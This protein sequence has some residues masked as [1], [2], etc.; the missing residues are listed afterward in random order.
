MVDT[1]VFV[2]REAELAYL[3]AALQHIL[4]GRGQ[5]RLISGKAGAGKSSLVGEFVRLAQQSYPDI[6][7]AAG[8]C[9]PQT[10]I[11]DPYLPFREI[12]LKMM[13]AAEPAQPASSPAQPLSKRMKQVAVFSMEA[14]LEVGPDL[15][16]MVL[17]GG[18][19]LAQVGRLAVEKT[20]WL[21]QF[22]ERFNRQEIQGDLKIASG[23]TQDQVFEQY[24][25]VL[26]KIAASVP[27]ILVVDD[28]HWADA[29]SLELLFHLCRRLE[30][31]RILLVGTFRP[32]ELGVGSGGERHPLD[33]L[34]NELKRY[35]G[36]ILL[37]LDA[38]TTERGRQ[39]VEALI[40]AEPND[41]DEIFR[42]SLFSHTRGHPLFT[43]EILR[44]LRESSGVVQSPGGKWI[45]SPQLDWRRLPAR[46][47]GVIAERISR[48][49]VT[50]QEELTVASIEGE[51]FTAEVVAAL[52]ERDERQLVRRLSGELQRIHQLVESD[53]LV[54]V[55]SQRLATYRFSHSLIW[56][57]LYDRVDAIEK[58]YL[59]EE[60]AKTLESLYGAFTQAY[61]IQLAYH[62]EQ[63]QVSDKAATYLL[64]A[65]QQSAERFAHETA[66]EYL[67]RAEGFLSG[68]RIAD[69]IELFETRV[70]I[71]AVLGDRTRQK[72]ALQEF[73][74][75]AGLT[76]DS[77]QIASARFY[78]GQYA[79]DTGDL[80]GAVEIGSHLLREI[81]D[82][83]PGTPAVEQLRVNASTLMGQGLRLRGS[84]PEARQLLAQAVDWAQQAEYLHGQ[85]L[86]L[87][88]LSMTY[89][90]EGD[91]ASAEPYLEDA[92]S[93]TQQ[94]DDPHREWSV[95][96]NLGVIAREQ[97]RSQEAITF[98]SRALEIARKIGDRMGESTALTNLGEIHFQIGDYTLARRYLTDAEKL[99]AEIGDRSGA[100]IS[101]AN[102]GE[103]ARALG[104]LPLAGKFAR[105]A[106]TLFQKTGFRMGQGIILGNLALMAQ[107]SGRA[108]LQRKFAEQSLAVA[109]EV[110]DRYGE[111]TSLNL[112]AQA[113]FATGETE[114]AG[115]LF[116]R[117][118][119]VWSKQ[120]DAVGLFQA[121]LGLA[122]C[123]LHRG[124]ASA[125]QLVMDLASQLAAQPDS[126][127]KLPLEV[128]LE[129][130]TTLAQLEKNQSLGDGALP[131]Q[132]LARLA[133]Q[134]LETRAG[135]ITDPADRQA[136]L[137]NVALHRRVLALAG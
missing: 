66:L 115:L 91:Y 105:Q 22:R 123:A 13:A 12:M 93:I 137:Q 95:L 89:W 47:E 36:E 19:F 100:G 50:V 63:A 113:M 85:V 72:D 60:T 108:D 8:L 110:S 55:G 77:L 11:K 96:S 84:I 87:N 109:L 24:S 49:P 78:E 39:F 92:L 126:L 130:Y 17:P 45:A 71:Y 106:F 53:R 111:G 103:C 119:D 67:V 121:Q 56:K 31:S 61:A 73:I 99:A 104:D 38:A 40:D 101:L 81:N 54:H 88:Q 97:G 43:V 64:I 129:L 79:L 37:D 34:I 41:L 44:D 5:L 68:S 65:G 51:L 7:Q 26:K 128:Y 124:D 32:E 3:D 80:D 25:N 58:A 122:G 1:P 46:V 134:V 98:Y 4:Q 136:F 15:A 75:L 28:L 10:G 120:E 74:K 132:D 57:Y 133:R 94:L 6:V 52:L 114:E 33:K 112:L 125:A 27:L 131:A 135:R 76:R 14:V 127:E 30:N 107:T 16:G 82:L 70:K 48:L 62:Y 23:L 21:D 9:D 118:S 18:K 86:A 117:A 102:L 29:A 42:R 59:H 20:G 90:S 35:Y 83:Q 69:R 116:A 2:A